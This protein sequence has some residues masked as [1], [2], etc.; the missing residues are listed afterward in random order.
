MP[1]GHHDIRA[2]MEIVIPDGVEIVAA[3]ALR[4]DQFGLLRLVFRHQDNRPAPGCQ[5]GG[6][7]DRA[8]DV[9]VRFVV[10]ALG[11]IEAET[12]KTKFLD[13]VAA[14]GDEKFADRPGVFAIEINR[15]APLV[16][17]SVTE[18]IAREDAEIVSVGSEMVV[19]YV[20]N[21]SQA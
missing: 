9:F 2:V 11:R 15:V 8:H 13:P 1:A 16:T 3:F 18:I 14:V 20:E 5:P 6:S 19:N 4:A 17:S 21:H 7:P 12:V 10:D